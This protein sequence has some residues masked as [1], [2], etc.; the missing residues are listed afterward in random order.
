MREEGE[1][2]FPDIMK[3][4]AGVPLWPGT[5]F[6]ADA[7][8]LRPH[9]VVSQSIC[10]SPIIERLTLQVVPRRFRDGVKP[11]KDDGRSHLVGFGF[12]K[13]VSE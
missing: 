8:V 1:I 4:A 6:A 13:D 7:K 10:Q 3:V 5:V 2:A 11:L 9:P 12:F